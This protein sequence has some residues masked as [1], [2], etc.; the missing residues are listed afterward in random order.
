MA[1]GTMERPAAATAGFSPPDETRI[2]YLSFRTTWEQKEALRR[3][4]DELGMTVSELVHRVTLRH[5]LSQRVS[6]T[7]G[8][9]QFVSEARDLYEATL[10]A[11]SDGEFDPV[12]KAKVTKKGTSFL[13]RIWNREVA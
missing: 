5:L 9:S 13:H 3:E 8:A 10:E 11:A 12:E 6:G 2:Q 4:A 1:T 7:P